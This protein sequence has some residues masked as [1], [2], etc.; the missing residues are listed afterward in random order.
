MNKET[1][2]GNDGLLHL[3]RIMLGIV[4]TLQIFSASSGAPE[5]ISIKAVIGGLVMTAVFVFYWP[6]RRKP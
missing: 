2:L 4:F 6:W 3:I 5:S 1:P